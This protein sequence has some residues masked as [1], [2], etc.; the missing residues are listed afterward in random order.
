VEAWQSLGRGSLANSAL[1]I[2][3]FYLFMFG[4]ELSHI[5]IAAFRF[6]RIFDRKVGK[7]KKKKEE[8]EF[9]PSRS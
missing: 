5:V 9:L 2:A 1:R 4:I 7:K 3:D 8:I 6:I